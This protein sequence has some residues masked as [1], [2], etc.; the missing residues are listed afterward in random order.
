MIQ[1]NYRLKE[2]ECEKLRDYIKIQKEEVE[3]F[4]KAIQ[5]DL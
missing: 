2:I 4:S 3:A 5:T 1:D